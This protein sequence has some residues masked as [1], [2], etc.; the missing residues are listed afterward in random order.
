MS[1]PKPGPTLFEMVSKGRP[2]VRAR[3][4]TLPRW[5]GASES[6]PQA[7]TRRP[8]TPQTDPANGGPI[9]DQ[10]RLRAPL[11]AVDGPRLLISLSSVSAGVVVF[12][13]IIV[14]AAAFLVGQSRGMRVGQADGF[15]RGQAA[16]ESDAL[17][18]IEKARRS[19]PNVDIFAGLPTSPVTDGSKAGDAGRAGDPGGPAGASPAPSDGSEPADALNG[20]TWVK[21][22]TYIVVQ[23]FLDQDLAEAEKARDFLKEHGI[24]SAV[25]T[26]TGR[27]NYKYRLVTQKGFNR[28]DPVQKRLCD[29]FHEKIRVLGDLFV[30]GGGRYNLQGY[31]KMATANH[32]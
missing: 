19:T 11:L 30:K 17:D 5:W 8:T 12:V 7:S 29:E 4:L 21:G 32:P 26:Y 3:R 25:V 10:D 18:G 27:S 28:D 9:S 31:Q 13:F 16:I 14:V 15:I 24:A 1:K 22:H 23:E 6:A 20:P 2:G